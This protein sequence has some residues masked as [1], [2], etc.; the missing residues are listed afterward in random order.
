M[1]NGVIYLKSLCESKRNGIEWYEIHY[2]YT[3]KQFLPQSLLISTSS[4]FTIVEWQWK[5]QKAPFW[6]CWRVL[7]IYDHSTSNRF[8]FQLKLTSWK[9]LRSEAFF[10]AFSNFMHTYIRTFIRTFP[11]AYILSWG[12]GGGGGG[13][14]GGEREFDEAV[15]A[16]W[17]T[18]NARSHETIL[19]IRTAVKSSNESK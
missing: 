14:R 2:L 16:D 13:G 6:F 15:S 3:C 7:R 19:F 10:R 11:Q 12:V 4:F 18:E 5:W 1:F 9:V 17:S 8:Q